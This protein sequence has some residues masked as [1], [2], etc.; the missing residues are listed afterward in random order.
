MADFTDLRMS[1]DM[2]CDRLSFVADFF[3]Q[4]PPAQKQ[5]CVSYEAAS[6]LIFILDDVKAHLRSAD[7]L[8]EELMNTK[9]EV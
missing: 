1:L 5:L 7:K 8:A 9:K 6:G 3:G 4:L 2:C